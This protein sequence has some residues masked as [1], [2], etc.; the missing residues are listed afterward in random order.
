MKKFEIAVLSVLLTG[1]AACDYV[2]KK[3]F[4]AERA[5]RQYQ[6]AMADYSAGRMDAAVVGFKKA[7]RANPANASARFQLACLLQDRK[8]DYLGALCCYREYLLQSPG[9]DKERMAKDRAALCEKLLMGEMAR[10]M[11][12]SD[13]S[14]AVKEL[15]EARQASESAAERLAL[16]ERRLAETEERNKALTRENARLRRMLATVGEETESSRRMDVSAA[17][18]VLDDAEGDR[19]KLSPDAKALFEE[20]EA[21]DAPDIAEGARRAEEGETADGPSLLAGRDGAADYTG[22]KLD[23]TRDATRKPVKSEPPHEARPEFYTVQEGDTLYRIA[24]RFYGRRDA[25]RKIL[26]AN[27]AAISSDA[28]IRTGQKLRLP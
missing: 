6:A 16:A 4:R 27:K 13:A 12:L 9:G 2:Q 26:D 22:P 18:A 8:Q 11:N 19:L 25:W 24:L 20:E 23:E 1:L 5:D 15:A 7:I 28:R 17:K 21:A 10:K 14:G 3:E